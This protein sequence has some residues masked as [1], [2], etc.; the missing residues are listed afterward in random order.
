MPPEATPLTARRDAAFDAAGR[1]IP[2]LRRLAPAL[3]ECLRPEAR[4]RRVARGCRVWQEG[5][6]GHEFTFLSQGRAKLAKAGEAGRDAIVDL[7][8]AG[9][10][11][12]AS[13]VACAA[14]YCCSAT[15]LDDAVEVLSL[16][17]SRVLELLEGSR[18]ASR[19]FVAEMARREMRLARR[20][21]ELSGGQLERRLAA[22]FLHLAEEFGGA[23][24]EGGVE[25]PIALNRQDLADLC[26]ARLETAIR[27]MRRLGREGV[28]RSLVRRGFLVDP[29][30]L[31][32]IVRGR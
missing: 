5:D 6:P 29:A 1:R 24:G 18:E 9:E 4:I 26:G 27:V 11:L 15:A 32:R 31:Q 12:S 16:P 19:A 22:L 20:I 23:R 25:V 13:A 10:L 8:G 17:R 3:L 30:G 14:P 28:V 21:G 2:F 7:C